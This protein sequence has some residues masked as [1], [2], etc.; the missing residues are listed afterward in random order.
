MIA[1]NAV[2]ICCPLFIFQEVNLKNERK[3]EKYMNFVQPIRDPEYIR[4]IKKYLFEW[5]VSP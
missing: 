2:V 3:E 1:A 4:V 5:N